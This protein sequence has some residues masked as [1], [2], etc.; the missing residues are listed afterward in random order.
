MQHL[1]QLIKSGPNLQ[2]PTKNLQKP[3]PNQCIYFLLSGILPLIAVQ[4]VLK[5]KV[6]FRPKR[7]VTCSLYSGH[8]LNATVTQR[9]HK[10]LCLIFG[11]FQ[12]FGIANSRQN[13]RNSRYS[14]K[15]NWTKLRHASNVRRCTWNWFNSC[16]Q[17]SADYSWWYYWQ[18]SLTFQLS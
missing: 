10:L 17:W 18:F 3:V 4:I 14:A 2:L 16:I 11:K 9:L 13:H 12:N 7:G 15:Y 8:E 5:W 1:S 6:L